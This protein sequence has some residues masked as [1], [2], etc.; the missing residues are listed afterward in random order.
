[1]L[2]CKDTAILI[3]QELDGELPLRKRLG[4][5]IHLLMCRSCA[6]VKTQLLFLKEAL[7]RFGRGEVPNALGAR[8]PTLSLE[9]RERI[10]RRM[11][12]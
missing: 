8:R 10:K 7:R 4:L 2:S 3:S 1:M 11:R 5:R 12:Q 6:R 9:L